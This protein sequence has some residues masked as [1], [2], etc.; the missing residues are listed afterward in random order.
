MPVKS[1]SDTKALSSNLGELIRSGHPKGKAASA[2]FKKA[3]LSED[4]IKKMAEGGFPDVSEEYNAENRATIEKYFSDPGFKQEPMEKKIKAWTEYEKVGGDAAKYGKPSNLPQMDTKLSKIPQP[5]TPAMQAL[6]EVAPSLKD[7]NTLLQAAKQSPGLQKVLADEAAAF[8]RENR[9]V[10]TNP[11]ANTPELKP[12]QPRAVAPQAAPV[13]LAATPSLVAEKPVSVNI[14]AKPAVAQ[15]I[16]PKVDTKLAGVSEIPVRTAKMRALLDAAPSLKDPAKL[17]AAVKISAAVAQA[18]KEEANAATEPMTEL[19][20]MTDHTI[21]ADPPEYMTEL[22]GGS[23]PDE[24][25]GG[26]SDSEFDKASR[27][28]GAASEAHITELKA[29]QAGLEKFIADPKTSDADRAAAQKQSNLIRVE[30]DRSV[31]GATTD[32]AITEEQA[33]YRMSP[34]YARQRLADSINSFGDIE[35]MP[36]YPGEFSVPPR[37]PGESDKDYGIRIQDAK[38]A[39][40][41]VSD[42]FFRDIKVNRDAYAQQQALKQ[43]GTAATDYNLINRQNP[44]GDAPATVPPAPVVDSATPAAPAPVAAPQ[45]E[46]RDSRINRMFNDQNIA[47]AESKI[48]QEREIATAD[49]MERERL[50]GIAEA[51]G[52]NPQDFINTPEHLRPALVAG[53]AELNRQTVSAQNAAKVQ[54]QFAEQEVA[55]KAKY[56][57]RWSEL[58]AQRKAIQ[59]SLR[60][61]EVDPQRWWNSQSMGQQ[62]WNAVGMIIGGIGAG[63]SRTPNQMFE[64]ISRLSQQ[65]L[66]AQRMEIGKKQNML[67]LLLQEGNELGQAN[68]ILHTANLE[69]AASEIE[70]SALQDKVP[71]LQA[72]K[73]MLVDTIRSN[74][75]AQRMAALKAQYELE[76][77]QAET[78]LKQSEAGLKQ[79]E[80]A[81]F[82]KGSGL[83]KEDAALDTK[84]FRALQQYE[85]AKRTK[86]MNKGDDAKAATIRR[87]AKMNMK[88]VLG[89]RFGLKGDDLD[90]HI[91]SIAGKWYQS[92]TEEDALEAL[93]KLLESERSMLRTKPTEPSFPKNPIP[94]R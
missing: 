44:V 36:G 88:Q 4:T 87:A 71:Q 84:M 33:A 27:Q 41:A 76:K 51:N 86:E 65:D 38:N 17:E 3:G 32:E 91:N 52:I 37:N 23:T 40:Q 64:T 18:V 31:R 19:K 15:D 34:A 21:P 82:G 10:A 28:R 66:E 55:R 35:K 56:E 39:W 75:A 90:K 26:M 80:A 13:Q 72:Q 59:E 93:A 5:K 24:R 57:A 92:G 14:P 60:T 30:L 83:S 58:E 6:W 63:I 43:R 62:M 69:W 79:A 1:G 50:T 25:L 7:P 53:M 9:A 48:N 54:Q 16:K 68:Q 45:V 20:G 74:A 73:A 78:A 61:T 46:S 94:T 42:K 29:Q 12:Q 8:E 2:A 11:T 81:R 70:K 67:T 47:T 89:E 85:L 49:T 77:L 22:K